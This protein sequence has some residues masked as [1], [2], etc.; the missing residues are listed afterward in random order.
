MVAP[1]I[2]NR[3]AKTGQTIPSIIYSRPEKK[4]TDFPL[5]RFIPLF[6]EKRGKDA[7]R[8]RFAGGGS[9]ASVASLTRGIRIT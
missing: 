2:L 5:F 9:T 1:F 8:P 4:Q 7:L 6:Q 3:I